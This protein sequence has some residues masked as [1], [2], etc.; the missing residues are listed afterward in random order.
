MR[1]GE[2][3]RLRRKRGR[4]STGR[5]LRCTMEFGIAS[6]YP[7]YVHHN[8]REAFRSRMSVRHPTIS[9]TFPATIV[10]KPIEANVSTNPSRDN[11]A[12]RVIAITSKT[13]CCVP[14]GKARGVVTPRDITSSAHQDEERQRQMLALIALDRIS[15]GD[16]PRGRVRSW[17]G[18]SL[19]PPRCSGAF[20]EIIVGTEYAPVYL[21]FVA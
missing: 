21:S 8:L 9:F 19:C 7:F 18:S 14:K 3:D 5:L 12:S 11:S 4:P 16:C 15:S 20:L 1:Q 17:I 10:G 6:S 13:A 2:A